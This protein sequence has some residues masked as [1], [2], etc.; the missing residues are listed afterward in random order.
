MTFTVAETVT[1]K[2]TDAFS[3]GDQF[4]VFVNSVLAF[5]TAA[6]PA[7]AYVEVESGVP[8]PATR[9]LAVPG[10]ALLTLRRRIIRK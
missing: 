5:T 2:V 1:L 7:D 9:L 3:K 4:D 6:V 10:L 8:E